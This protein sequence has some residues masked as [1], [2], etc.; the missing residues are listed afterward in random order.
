MNANEAILNFRNALIALL[1][2]IEKANILWKSGEAYD[3]WDAITSSLYN[4]LVGGPLAWSDERG[5]CTILPYETIIEKI[6]NYSYLEVRNE[7]LKDKVYVF[8][9][10]ATKDAPF[11]LVLC[12][13][14]IGK[15]TIS[16]EI[17]AVKFEETVYEFVK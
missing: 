14:L 16:N 17:E 15:N 11:D 9:A 4:G 3:E 12:R 6:A 8:Y 7:K 5:E 2:S 13:A 10:F 1:P